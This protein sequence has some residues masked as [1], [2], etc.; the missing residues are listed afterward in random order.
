MSDDA[1]AEATADPGEPTGSRRIIRSFSALRVQRFR[2]VWGA[3]VL[4]MSGN[5]MQITGR[6]VLVYELTG[7]TAALGLIYFVSFLPQLVLSTFAGV[8]ADAIDRRKVLIGGQMVMASCAALMGVLTVTH[9]ATLWNVG[10]IS[11]G[12]GLMQTVVMPSMQATVRSLVPGDHLTSAI[13]LNSATQAAT[14]V[15]GPLFAGALIPLVGLPWLFFGNAISFIPVVSV[16]VITKLPPQ[17]PLESSGTIRAV[18]EGVRYVRNT[19]T[20]G[21]ALVVTFVIVGLGNVYQ[22][23]AVA[24]STDV[25]ADGDTELGAAYYGMLQAAL[26]TGAFVGILG[27]TDMAKRRTARSITFTA[28]G[29]GVALALLAL[30]EVPAVAIGMGAFVGLFHFCTATLCQTVLQHHAPEAML[31]RVLS[32]YALAFVGSMPILGL[33]GGQI[34]EVVGTAPTF[35][36]VAAGSLL[37]TVGLALRWSRYLPQGDAAE[38]PDP[39]QVRTAGQM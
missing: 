35:L 5:W 29:F 31:G 8:L 12:M 1:H 19:P 18:V 2:R 30:T 37:F 32:L 14:R 24:Y 34:A 4:S 27:V 7:S 22:P 33:V 15:I 23:L 9:T 28:G 21:V 36:G 3:N 16:W 13:S 20:L 25:L 26:G 38:A 6:A 11:L 17:P 39:V 10:A